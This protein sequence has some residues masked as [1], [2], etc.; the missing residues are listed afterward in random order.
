MNN[1]TRDNSPLAKKLKACY[2]KVEACE[3]K[4]EKFETKCKSRGEKAHLTN[5]SIPELDNA[6]LRRS[7]IQGVNNVNANHPTPLQRLLANALGEKDEG[8]PAKLNT[9][10]KKLYHALLISAYIEAKGNITIET[11]RQN[12]EEKFN[13]LKDK[14][15]VYQKLKIIEA[16]RSKDEAALNNAFEE[17]VT[18]ED[19]DYEVKQ[20]QR[21]TKIEQVN[22]KAQEKKASITSQVPITPQQYEAMDKCFNDF[23][24]AVTNGAKNQAQLDTLINFDSI[25]DNDTY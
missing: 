1:L 3:K 14:V 24:T 22:Q 6:F 16:K 10:Q 2:V 23:L 7:I 9:Q 5:A 8:L 25:I 20:Q 21:Q 12:V 11:L 17:K 15:D 18:I 13:E 19:D 4:I